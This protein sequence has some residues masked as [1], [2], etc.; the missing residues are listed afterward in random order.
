VKD[1]VR[2]HGSAG[3]A[4]LA[5]LMA[6]A[7]T[8][9]GRVTP[10]ELEAL[11]EFLR[12]RYANSARSEFFTLFRQAV[13]DRPDIERIVDTIHEVLPEYPE[14]VQLYATIRTLLAA[15]GMTAEESSGIVKIAALLDIDPADADLLENASKSVPEFRYPL[16]RERFICIGAGS[17][18]AIAGG[19]PLRLA[20]MQ[21]AGLFAV[22]S[23]NDDL[24]GGGVAHPA[25]D[26]VFVEPLGQL[27][28]GTATLS[29][30]DLSRLF[31]LA[32]NRVSCTCR[33]VVDAD[34]LVSVGESGR[35][36]FE[37]RV[38]HTELLFLRHDAEAVAY[39]NGAALETAAVLVPADVL[40]FD[41]G[42]IRV[43]QIVDAL[44]HSTWPLTQTADPAFRCLVSDRRVEGAS[45][46]LADAG[47][48]L[49]VA[50][51]ESADEAG[52]IDV[53]CERAECRLPVRLGDQP[54]RPGARIRVSEPALL[55]IGH[56]WFA[57]DPALGKIEYSKR[58]VERFEARNVSYRFRNV[59][60]LSGI[61]FAAHAGELV[62]IMGASGAGKS[63]LLGVL[64]GVLRPS[65]GAVLLNGE[66]LQVQLAR[67]R[68]I[69]GYVPQDDLV[70]DNLTVAENLLYS[71]RIRL[72]DL[73]EAELRARVA[74][75]LRDIGLA[76]K[77]DLRV[78]NPVRKVLS[79]GQRKRL[80]IG[81]ELLADAELFF[82]DE[83]TSGLSSQDS[84]TIV[85]LLRQLTRRGKLVFVVIH[86][87]SS[88]IYKMFDTLLVLDTGGVLV[89]YGAAREAVRHFKEFLPNHRDFVE[90]PACGSINPET[91]LNAI[92][93]PLP[94]S[95]APVE[96]APRK[97][98]SEFWRN[99]FLVGR[100]RADR[101][102]PF[103]PV[104]LPAAAPMGLSGRM[105]S[106]AASVQR[107]F[108]DRARN[109]TN[110]VMS[111][112]APLVLGIVMA[113]MLR[114]PDEPYTYAGNT[115]LPK[116][117]FLSTIVFVF[118][119]LMASVNEVIRE[120]ALIRRE[121][122]AGFRAMQ[123]VV[124]KTTAFLPFSILQVGL[125]SAL[126]AF[127]LQFPYRAPTYV[128][129]QP[130]VPFPWYFALVVFL[131]GQASFALGLLIS[132]LLRSE[133]A[134]FNWIP[135][136]IIPQ[137]L[138]GGVFVDFAEMPRLVNRVVPEY[139]E[140][141]FSRWG[142]EALLAGEKQFNP[143]DHLNADSIL[144]LM[145]AVRR[146]SGRFDLQQLIEA[147]RDRWR[148]E[149]AL[150][151]PPPR[152]STGVMQNT[153][154]R[155]LRV[156]DRTA[157]ADFLEHAYR[158]DDRRVYTIRPDLPPGSRDR[159]AAILTSPDTGWWGSTFAARAVNAT[160]ESAR[161]DANAPDPERTSALRQILTDRSDFPAT[162]RVIEG[163]SVPV[164]LWN[165]LVLF[166][167]TVLC[168]ALSILRLKYEK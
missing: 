164:A 162:V 6:F 38:N 81:L 108:V 157:D 111:A 100:S 48:P 150:L 18:G 25:H 1:D 8:A 12:R 32:K 91:I 27:S 37:F 137:I 106:V 161:T 146:R 129:L 149:R 135:L 140:L 103:E 19:R 54:L 116:F 110:I 145:Q 3:L 7:V 101:E 98:D 86:Q 93:Q 58:V 156:N 80:N 118:F 2:A 33:L 61:N 24:C 52:A 99:A 160:L 88:D 89:W 165:I 62:G 78:G 59:V 16:N 4:P 122:V 11:Q 23:A 141:A 34:R 113:A 43:A 125:Y 126:A 14:R 124:A 21:L 139:A 136:L 84:K 131:I 152:I 35:A 22:S 65:E 153:L 90:C 114:G 74:H 119:G 40:R 133:A 72:P 9:D 60:G 28:A 109:R 39:L 42:E 57:I 94:V 148:A 50:M 123:Y 102:Q 70:M 69:L 44:D 26:I 112:A 147:P 143:S 63:T 85:R 97:F 20:A 41:G 87:P 46:V 13:D 36:A 79:G 128:P 158:H 155:L 151:L 142:Y 15:S 115:A 159:L 144:A 17:S 134:A 107:A 47:G 49:A 168:H 71:G 77:K 117:L 51:H 105:R 96:E 132:S 45:H 82:L 66:D 53:V 5:Q 167:M 29:F 130:L 83:P 154:L 31:D 95:A 163:A 92:E 104:P 64:L 55:R 138:L 120:Q 127:V 68:S 76:D 75:V 67:R 166:V 30:A 73:P 121:R 56:H 10:E